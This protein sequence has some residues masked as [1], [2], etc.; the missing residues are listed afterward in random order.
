MRPSLATRLVR[1]TTRHAA[2]AA[3]AATVTAPPPPAA[4][5]CHTQLDAHPAAVAPV[6]S[7]SILSHVWFSSSA[8]YSLPENGPEGD[9]K[10]PNERTLKLGKTVRILHERLPTLLASPLPQDILS[11]QISLHLFPSTHPHLPTVSGRIAYLA[12]LWTAP[13]A[14]GR[15]PVVGNVKLTVISER[16]IRHGGSNTSSASRDEKLIVKWKTCGKARKKNSA[17]IYRGIGAN[18]QVERIT[19]VLGGKARDDEEFCGLF[20]FE[21]DDQG[22][23][24]KHT[25]EH[26][27]EGSGS[28]RTNRVVSVTDWLLGK[29]SGQREEHVPSLAWCKNN[30]VRRVFQGRRKG[31]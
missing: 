23:I 17:G 9:H 20:I 16:M 10:P 18:E 8:P 11:P 22:R 7:R 12:A 25:I 14:W 3:S 27:D 29:V 24:V 21:F 31:D 19:D 15:V 2:A 6:P 26:A 5:L 30:H 1:T 4:T 13:V 28:E